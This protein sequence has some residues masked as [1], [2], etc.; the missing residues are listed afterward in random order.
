MPPGVVWDGLP[1]GNI[2]AGGLVV[3]I[4]LLILTDRLVWHKRLDVVT[5]RVETQD[6]LISELTRQ[7]T[8][9]LNSAIPTVNAVLTALHTAAG[10]RS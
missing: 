6:E 7:N 3:F 4:V 9:L 8:M 1:V 2:G 10:D 5:K